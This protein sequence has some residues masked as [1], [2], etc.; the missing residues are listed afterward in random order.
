[1]GNRPRKLYISRMSTVSENLKTAAAI[2][3]RGQEV[4]ASA[5][6]FDH[7]AFEEDGP[8]TWEI[9]CVP[10]RKRIRCRGEPGAN[11]LQR[12]CERGCSRQSVKKKHPP[13]R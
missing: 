12:R 10:R 5:G 2:K 4:A 8:A 7:G 11:N 13:K 9:P 1:M 6:E 3:G